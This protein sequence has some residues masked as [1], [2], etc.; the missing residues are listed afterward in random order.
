MLAGKKIISGSRVLLG[1]RLEGQRLLQTFA[2]FFDLVR[3][4][5]KAHLELPLNFRLTLAPL[6]RR[7][8]VDEAG[9]DVGNDRV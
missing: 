3:E 5:R 6:L 2:G 9:I 7:E 8:F 4:L 1:V